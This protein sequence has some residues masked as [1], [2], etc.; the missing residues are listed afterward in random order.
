MAI[1]AG[2]AHVSCGYVNN[3][4]GSAFIGPRAWSE[5]MSAGGQAARPAVKSTLPTQASTGAFLAFRFYATVDSWVA[6][7]SGTPNPSLASGVA[8]QAREFVAAGTFA[9]LFCSEGDS[10]VWAAA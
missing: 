9:D 7:G 4:G 2:S 3:L 1:A 10:L 8:N 6:W 5:T